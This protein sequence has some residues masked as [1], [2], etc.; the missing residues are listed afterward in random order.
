MTNEYLLNEKI[1]NESILIEKN[2]NFKRFKEITDR[3]NIKNKSIVIL[4]K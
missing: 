2:I 3:F 4:K 1:D